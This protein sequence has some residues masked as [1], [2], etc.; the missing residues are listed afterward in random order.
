MAFTWASKVNGILTVFAIGLAVIIDLWDILDIKK[1]HSLV[2]TGPL[3]YGN[4]ADTLLGVLLETV[5]CT[6]HRLH[7]APAVPL[8]FH[9]LDPSRPSNK[10]RSRR[11]LYEPRV[12]RDAARERTSA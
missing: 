11:H 3:E 2:R 1:G 7:C 12:P 5:C 8:P 4:N 6:G 9:L 10:L